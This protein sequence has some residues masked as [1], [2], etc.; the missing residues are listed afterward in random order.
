MAEYSVMMSKEDQ[1][2]IMLALWNVVQAGADI[3]D[4]PYRKA[5]DRLVAK[6]LPR[7]VMAAEG[8]GAY[9]GMV[10]NG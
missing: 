5:F 3:Y 1:R 10:I 8:N 6:G 2:T 4:N 9:Q 7:P